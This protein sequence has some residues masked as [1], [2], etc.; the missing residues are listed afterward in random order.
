VTRRVLDSSPEQPESRPA[1]PAPSDAAPVSWGEFA[2]AAA[3]EGEPS[4][5]VNMRRVLATLVR[6]K[7]LLVVMTVLGT[8][9][10]FVLTR[11]VPSE[12]AAQAHSGSRRGGS[13]RPRSGSSRV[14]SS[15]VNC[16]VVLVG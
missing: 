5:T 2:S 16:P 10:G 15:R 3:P 8:A 12:Y 4:Q 13:R 11:V 6:H 14:P 1:L 9:V 7:W